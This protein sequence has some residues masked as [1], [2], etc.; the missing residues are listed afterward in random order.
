MATA[1]QRKKPQR[2]RQTGTLIP[3]GAAAHEHTEVF[4]TST[5]SSVSG[6]TTTS[7]GPLDVPSYGFMRH[8]QVYVELEKTAA[9]TTPAETLSE[10]FP[11]NVIST[12]QL[13]DVNGAPIFGPMTG[14]QCY[15]ANVFGGYSFKQ[16][17]RQFA[18]DYTIESGTAADVK[19]RFSLRVPVE[20]HHSTALGCLANQN[21]AASYKLSITLASPNDIYATNPPS[22]AT[23][24]YRVKCVLEAWSLPDRVDR[25]G[26][27][28]AQLPPLH[29]TTQFWSASSQDVSAGRDSIQ[30]HRVGNLIR[31]IVLVARVSG[32][33][34]ANSWGD[35]YYDDLLELWWDNRQQHSAPV[36]YFKQ[37]MAEAYLT[38]EGMTDAAST[39]TDTVDGY[40]EGVIAFPF[41]TDVLGHGGDGTPELW[42]PTA[43]STRLEVIAQDFDASDIDVIINEIGPVEVQQPERFSE[44]SET[45]TVME[46]FEG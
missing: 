35:N 40:F 10:D 28:Q 36:R 9:G 25:A 2:A 27:P 13:S 3:F 39:G 6:S 4:G 19:A 20:I 38:E 12:I 30:I 43:Q 42:L 24:Q 26:R 32:A 46:G 29:G 44:G 15:L 11:W 41:D 17:P 7:I 18:G 23:Y 37:K 34:E 5:T 21:A 33:R 16:D 14:Y 8:I 45:G 22:D 31:N 1:T